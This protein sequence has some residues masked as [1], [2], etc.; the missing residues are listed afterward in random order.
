MLAACSIAFPIYAN[1]PSDKGQAKGGLQSKL[2]DE[3]K[4]GDSKVVENEPKNTAPSMAFLEYLA[5]L[6]QVEGKWIS[7][8]DLLA[9]PDSKTQ[10]ESADKETLVPEVNNKEETK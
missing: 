2:A 3:S 9:Q 1:S 8:L 5:E 4:R 7:P 10:L 6:K